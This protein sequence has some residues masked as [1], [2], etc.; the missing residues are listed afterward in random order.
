MVLMN[1]VNLAV[2]C[3]VYYS[4]CGNASPPGG[5]GA[6][7][8]GGGS[9]EGAW[10]EAVCH[11]W[12]H[13]VSASSHS[14]F[15]RWVIYGEAATNASAVAPPDGG[16]SRLWRNPLANASSSGGSV[17]QIDFPL[18]GMVRAVQ[19]VWGRE[20]GCGRCG[21]RGDCLE[22]AANRTSCPCI[23]C[24]W[25]CPSPALQHIQAGLAAH[26]RRGPRVAHLHAVAHPAAALR[27]QL[28]G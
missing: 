2:A 20:G 3:S 11:K 16:G 25:V 14:A 18:D 19:G 4:F 28:P 17:L 8:G 1:S 21:G 12:L 6:A 22:A 27:R 9:Q 13:P 7:G 10:K 15:T 24:S 26:P 5:S 23:C